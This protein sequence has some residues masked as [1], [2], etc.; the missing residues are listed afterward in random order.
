MQAGMQR[1]CAMVYSRLQILLVA[2]GSKKKPGQAG[3]ETFVVGRD[4][5]PPFLERDFYFF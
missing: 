5:L 4:S 3:E 2:R 1:G